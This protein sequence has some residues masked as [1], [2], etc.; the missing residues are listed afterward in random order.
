ML[1]TRSLC[2][3][4]IIIGDGY[5]TNHGMSPRGSR[6]SYD[7]S[8]HL[9][10]IDR[11][12]ESD[13]TSDYSDKELTEESFCSDLYEVEHVLPDRDSEECIYDDLDTDRGEGT[14]ECT[15]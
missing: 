8:L 11:Q 4:P 15:G 7:L 13:Y 9:S 1:S 6:G 12:N 14:S 2:R 5:D 10:K 3:T